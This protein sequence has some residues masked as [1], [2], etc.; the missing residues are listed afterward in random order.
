[1]IF[2][3]P[4]TFLAPFFYFYRFSKKLMW[5]GLIALSAC[6]MWTVQNIMHAHNT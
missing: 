2:S 1:M 5:T 4:N 6:V 3:S